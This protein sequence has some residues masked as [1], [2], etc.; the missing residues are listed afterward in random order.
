MLA[1]CS[2]AVG[3]GTGAMVPHPGGVTNEMPLRDWGTIV[4]AIDMK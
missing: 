1:A 2:H 4:H 3:L